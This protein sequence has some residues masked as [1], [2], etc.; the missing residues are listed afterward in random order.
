MTQTDTDH[1]GTD[2]LVGE[3]HPLSR[4]RTD[5]SCRQCGSSLY[6]R[7]IWRTTEARLPVVRCQRCGT[8]APAAEVLPYRRMWRQRLGMMLTLGW[9]CVLCGL[10]A[11]VVLAELASQSMVGPLDPYWN[12]TV[13]HSERTRTLLRWLSLIGPA[14]AFAGGCLLA[15]A[16]YHWS[17]R[18]QMAAAVALPMLALLCVWMDRVK[19]ERWGAD[20]RWPVYSMAGVQ[21]VSGVLGGL[22]GR[23]LLRALLPAWLRRLFAFLWRRDGKE[24]PDA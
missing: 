24:I 5:L 8:I 14:A 17:A 19:W 1:A 3:D 2:E 10:L 23:P 20:G 7:P 22:A 11:V 12:W 9:L 16:M 21:I 6:A 15:C 13:K 4:A 18:A